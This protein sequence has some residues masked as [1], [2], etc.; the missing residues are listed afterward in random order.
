M[1]S[2]LVQNCWSWQFLV[3][4]KWRQDWYAVHI[5]LF[6]YLSLYLISKHIDDVYV[7]MYTN[8]QRLHCFIV[9]VI[10]IVLLSVRQKEFPISLW[11]KIRNTIFYWLWIWYT[12]LICLTPHLYK[13]VVLISWSSY[14]FQVNMWLVQKSVICQKILPGT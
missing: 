14:D 13:M 3:Y 2:F 7:L 8:T 9:A 6:V 1:P 12:H 11:L 5:C 10:I 4:T